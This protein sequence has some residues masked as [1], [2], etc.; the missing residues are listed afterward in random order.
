MCEAL[1]ALP[2]LS[3]VNKFLHSQD[4][5]NVEV[6]H[7]LVSCLFSIERRS[8]LLEKLKRFHLSQIEAERPIPPFRMQPKAAYLLLSGLRPTE[9]FP[10]FSGRFKS[11]SVRCPR[12]SSP[13]WIAFGPSLRRCPTSFPTSATQSTIERKTVTG[14]DP[15]LMI[16]R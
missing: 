11:R 7:A 4:R 15:M 6:P 5:Q 14:C 2:K 1:R 13:C 10:P 12:S 8:R 3:W 9:N 16:D